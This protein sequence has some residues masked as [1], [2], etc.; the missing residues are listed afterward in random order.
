[1][2]LETARKVLR[3]EL[4]ALERPLE[5]LDAANGPAFGERLQ[6]LKAQAGSRVI[7]RPPS[8]PLGTSFGLTRLSGLPN[9]RGNPSRL[10]FEPA[11]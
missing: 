10:P 4:K 3:T 9:W 5:R 1:M 2:S 11:T 6:S 8:A 7:V